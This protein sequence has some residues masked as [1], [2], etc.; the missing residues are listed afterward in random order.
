M[1]KANYLFLMV[2]FASV[3]LVKG[4]CSKNCSSCGVKDGANYC[5]VCEASL[6]MD[7]SCN[8][9][10]PTGCKY[11]SAVGCLA[12]NDGFS[13][14]RDDYTCSAVTGNN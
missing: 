11:H 4:D 13:L 7:G 8:G 5:F 10:A 1:G 3:C 14:S 6:W 9:P 12:C 2:L